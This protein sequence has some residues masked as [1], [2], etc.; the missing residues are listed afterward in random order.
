MNCSSGVSNATTSQLIADVN[1]FNIYKKTHMLI[2]IV[3][4]GNPLKKVEVEAGAVAADAISAAGFNV[5]SVTQIKRNA[6]EIT[7][8]AALNEGDTLVVVTGKVEGGSD[9]APIT[10]LVVK[11]EVRE[12]EVEAPEA[13]PVAFQ[14]SDLYEVAKQVGID[15]NSEFFFEDVEGNK[16]PKSTTPVDG[17][18]YTLVIVR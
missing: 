14:A 3:S 9:E 13:T 17:S 7:G 6:I 5:N 15:L 8:G 4:V 11:V 1:P 12:K 18:T 10:Q 16:L 2:T